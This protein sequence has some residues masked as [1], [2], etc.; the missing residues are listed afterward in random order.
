MGY[1]HYFQQ[2]KDVEPEAWQQIIDHF[3]RLLTLQLVKGE[4]LPIQFESDHPSP[5]EINEECIRFNGIG[6]EGCETM[7]LERVSNK[8]FTFCKTRR[9]AYDTSV[10]AL[11]IL[12]DHFAPGAY[13]IQ[14]DGDPTDWLPG[15]DLVRQV[16]PEAQSPLRPWKDA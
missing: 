16:L 9:R 11:L 1:T 12:A 10:V 6:E 5:P 15:L 8:Q 3:R 7:L 2:L 4:P 14:S 13:E